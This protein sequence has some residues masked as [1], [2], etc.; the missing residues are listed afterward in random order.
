MPVV[1]QLVELSSCSVYVRRAIPV[2]H[3]F[4]AQIEDEAMAKALDLEVGYYD[5]VGELLE[6]SRLRQPPAAAPATPMVAPVSSPASD[7]AVGGVCVGIAAGATAVRSLLGTRI[8]RHPS[9]S[10]TVA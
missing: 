10:R 2:F 8:F 9:C 7:A 4:V 6:Q 3:P 5:A 1:T